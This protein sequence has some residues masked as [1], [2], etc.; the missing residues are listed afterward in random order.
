MESR[1]AAILSSAMDAIVSVDEAQRIILFNRS[2]E[3]MFE[4]SAA[5]ALGSSLARFLPERFRERHEGWVRSFGATGSTARRMGALGEVRALRADGSEFEVEASISQADTPEGKVYTVVL[6]D[7]TDRKAFEAT[8]RARD[9]ELRRVQRI[10]RVGTWEMDARGA[11][12]WS[13]ET[14]RI[15]G[16][17][18]G[19]AAPNFET[20][21]MD[22]HPDDRDAV[23]AFVEGLAA[24]PGE[25]QVE[26]RVTAGN[27][28]SRAVLQRS[29]VLLAPDGGAGRIVGTIQDITELRELE[30]RLLQARKLDSIGRLAGGVAHDFNDLLTDV[31][32][33]AEILEE[34]LG[35][36]PRLT[37]HV[38]QVRAA[39]ERAA[40]LTSHLLA[41]ARHQV[42]RP[43]D[44]D[45]NRLL[46]D[47]ERLLRRVLGE[48]IELQISTSSRRGSVR[49]DPARFE[50][51]L[52]SLAVNARDAMP[53]GGTVRIETL[54]VT[55]DAE[56][57][58]RHPEVEPGPYVLLAVSD[59]GIGMDVKTQARAF[60]PLFT[61][62]PAGKGTG[63]GLS[64]AYGIVRQAG[65]H[66]GLHSEPGRGTTV[67][68][69]LPVVEAGVEVL[70]GP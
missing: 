1:L 3:A 41:F 20:F 7:I 49:I 65:G 60:E 38:R 22:V 34:A 25:R 33:H 23:R 19:V 58:K 35:G 45:L 37:E 42:V 18:A 11:L 53:A 63:L 14:F 64:T 66:I 56:D 47:V 39:A 51:V 43:C 50:E 31:L 59:T 8:L 48:T 52:V 69:R 27:G 24:S 21:L 40:A 54:D 44:V 28:E 9:E 29:A 46:R 10:G 57:A 55:L 30:Q 13:E 6:R 17:D 4:C 67:E 15:V 32:G 70:D 68:I 2:A 61:T 62:K 26:Y 16:R 12:T 5:D 36:D